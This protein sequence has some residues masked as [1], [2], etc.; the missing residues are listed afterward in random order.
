MNGVDEAARQ[1][2]ELTL[3]EFVWIDL[4][5]ALSAAKRDA[6]ERGLPGH[7][8][9]ERA[10]VIHIH[11]GVIA[12]PSLVGAERIIVLDAVADVVPDRA[13][14]LC[15][16]ELDAKLAARRQ[17]HGAHRLVEIERIEG[18]ADKVVGGLVRGA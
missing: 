9:G 14:I 1:A 4:N 15:D 6:D 13:I 16:D 8:A 5:A 7:Q 18:L 3:G 12:K 2:L 17:Q 11:S 10:H